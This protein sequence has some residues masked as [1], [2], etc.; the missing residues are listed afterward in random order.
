MCTADWTAIAAWVQAIGSLL[1]LI[2]AIYVPMRLYQREAT[3]RAAERLNR[4]RTNALAFRMDL[5]ALE[6]VLAQIADWQPR[7]RRAIDSEVGTGERFEDDVV[8]AIQVF[9]EREQYL[10][11][12]SELGT[13]TESVQRFFDRLER[14][15]ALATL[16]PFGLT[17]PED[18]E[19]LRQH[20]AS[21]LAMA[22]E[23]RG[24]IN[25]LFD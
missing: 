13:A 2:I 11:F 1:A 20:F 9:P 15:R 14:I 19:N 7:T 17:M 12:V 10:P 18:L 4:A 16:L 21:A 6:S 25:R 5:L 22:R 3:E 8:R 24:Q 23:A